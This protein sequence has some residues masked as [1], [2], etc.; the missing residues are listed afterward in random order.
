TYEVEECVELVPIKDTSRGED[1]LEFN[2]SS[3]HALTVECQQALCL[4]TEG[5]PQMTGS[6]DGAAPKF[7]AQHEFHHSHCILHQRSLPNAEAAFWKTPEVLMDSHITPTKSLFREL[8]DDGWLK[9]LTFMVDI[10]ER[11]NGLRTKT[12]GRNKVVTALYDSLR[13]QKR[14]KSLFHPPALKSHL[15]NVESLVDVQAEQLGDKISTLRQQFSGSF[16]DFKDFEK[17]CNISKSIFY[18]GA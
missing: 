3:G 18:E 10:T 9:N 2:G 17:D 13:K 8:Q 11:L 7:E 1:V 14:E 5:A 4:A 6:E 15:G 12:Q 16:A